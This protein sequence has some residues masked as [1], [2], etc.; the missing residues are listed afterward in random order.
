MVSFAPPEGYERLPA[1]PKKNSRS[2]IYDK[3]ILVRPIFPRGGPEKWFC[4]VSTCTSA[5]TVR[6]NKKNITDHLRSVHGIESQRTKKLLQ[7]RLNLKCKITKE[8][9]ASSSGL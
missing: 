6:T 1:P 7:D 9:I 8:K 2:I 5:I 3:D 4:M